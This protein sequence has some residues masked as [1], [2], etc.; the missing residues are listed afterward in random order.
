M[1]IEELKKKR[2]KDRENRYAQILEVWKNMKPFKTEDD[3]PTPPIVKEE[4]YKNIIIPNLIRCGAIPKKDLEDGKTYIGS[5]RNASEAIWKG[6]H[7]TYIRR[8][9]GMAYEEDINHFEDD[10]GHDLFIPIKIKE[11]GTNCKS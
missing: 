9:F 10:D 1:E 11:D 6:N 3:I 2:I 7:F 4:D 8:K 5:C